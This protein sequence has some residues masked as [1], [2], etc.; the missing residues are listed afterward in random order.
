MAIKAGQNRLKNKMD[1]IAASHPEFVEAVVHY[2]EA[3]E[4]YTG[5][6]QRAQ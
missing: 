2:V 6:L 4:R 3:K 1:E 5:A